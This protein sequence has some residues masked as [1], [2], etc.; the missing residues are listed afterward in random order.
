M[1]VFLISKLSI[2]EVAF[3]IKLLIFFTVLLDY[4]EGFPGREEDEE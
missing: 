1:T 4:V 3:C 2:V